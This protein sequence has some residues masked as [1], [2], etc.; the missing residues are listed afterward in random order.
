[1]VRV[2][3]PCPFVP[4]RKF[5]RTAP[6]MRQ[7]LTPRCF[8]KSASSTA[9]MALRSTGGMSL[10]ATTTRFSMANSPEHAAVGGVDL[11]DDV[12]LEVLEGRDLGQV[13]LV[14]QEDAE[15]RAADDRDHEQQQG[16][17]PSQRQVA[18]RSRNRGGGGHDVSLQ[19]PRRGLQTGVGYWRSLGGR[20]D[21]SGARVARGGGAWR[22]SFRGLA[23]G[24]EAPRSPPL[25]R[26]C[27]GRDCSRGLGRTSRSRGLGRTS[28]S[29]GLGRT[30]RVGRDSA[31]RGRLS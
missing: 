31:G 9:T 17:G 23:A 15:E 4:V 3:E 16:D 2:E 13:A 29:R 10:K 5:A 14:G 30:S 18:R 21:C 27:G 25:G 7:G 12:G 26:A 11:G 22:D 24:R 6:G 19:R 1:M 8:Q 28:R 20:R